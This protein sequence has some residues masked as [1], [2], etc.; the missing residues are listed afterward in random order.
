MELKFKAFSHGQ[1][2]YSDD[3]AYLL[4]EYDGELFLVEDTQFYLNDNPRYAKIGKA[5]Q[6]TGKLDKNKEELFIDDFIEDESGNIFL[7]GWRDSSIAAIHPPTCGSEREG[8][9]KWD[10]LH[11]LMLLTSVEKIGDIHTTPELLK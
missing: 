8:E 2:W 11:D 10:Y 7:I 5:I 3:E 1:W 6:F 9:C 4:K